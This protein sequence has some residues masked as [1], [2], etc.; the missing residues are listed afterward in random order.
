MDF[1]NFFR[2]LLEDN[3]KQIYENIPLV[4]SKKITPLCPAPIPPPRKPSM[5]Q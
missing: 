4:E 2:L 1:N 3:P 5:E